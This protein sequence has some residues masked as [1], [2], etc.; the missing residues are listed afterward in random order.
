MEVRRA[1]GK[2]QELRSAKNVKVVWLEG[3]D[4]SGGSFHG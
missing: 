1:P 3:D 2:R 4:S